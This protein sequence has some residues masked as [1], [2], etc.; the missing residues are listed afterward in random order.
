MLLVADVAAD[1]L[2]VDDKDKEVELLEIAFVEEDAEGLPVLVLD[3]EDRDIVTVVLPVEE[4][5]A[6]VLAL[7]LLDDVVDPLIGPEVA[8][9]ADVDVVTYLEVLVEEPITEVGFQ[10]CQTW[11]PPKLVQLPPPVGKGHHPLW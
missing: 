4:E 7:P 8:D 6:E 3:D 2:V 1:T 5:D 9:V 10:S 11:S